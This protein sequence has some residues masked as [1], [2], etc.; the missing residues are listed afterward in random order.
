MGRGVI[1]SRCRAA[2]VI[3]LE[4][5]HLADLQRA[6]LKRTGMQEQAVQLLLGVLDLEAGAGGAGDQPAVADLAAELAVERS[7]IDDHRAA[8]ADFQLG[9]ALAIFTSATISPDEASAS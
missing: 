4:I 7:L 3:D 2:G 1:G 6:D 8:L 9:D 5:D